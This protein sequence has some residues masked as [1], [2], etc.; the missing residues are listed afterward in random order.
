MAFQ[1]FNINNFTGGISSNQK[2]GIPNSCRFL[3]NLNIHEDLNY[4]TLH[5]KTTKISGST[6]TDLI[7]WAEDGTPYD[8]N[9][10]FYDA[11]GNIYKETSG[12]TWSVDRSGATIA[13]GAAGQGLKVFDDA[14]YYATATT[15]G[16][17]WKLSNSPTYSD[18]FLTDNTTDLDPGISASLDTSGSTYTLPSAISETATNRQTFIPT[19]DPIRAI[20][21]NVNARGTGNWTLT[22]HDSA[23]NSVGALT[24]AN[25]SVAAS[26][27]QKFTFTSPLRITIGNSYHFHVTSSD[28]TGSVVTT[29]LND[30]ETADFHTYFGILISDT[31]WHPMEQILNMLVVGNERYLAT[32]DQALYNPNKLVF[33]PGFKVRAL[34]KWRE[35]IVAAC[36]RGTNIDSFE[37]GRLYFWDGI[38]STFNFFKDVKMGLPNAITNSDERLFGVYGSSGEL[39]INNEPFQKVQDIPKVGRGKKVEVYPGAITQWQGQTLIGVAGSTDDSTSLEQGIYSFGSRQEGQP[40]VLS[41]PITIS[42]GTTQGTT[43]KIGMV[44]GFGKDLYIG[45]RD[46]ST[47]GVDKIIKTDTAATSGSWESLIFDDGKPQKTKEVFKIVIEFEALETGE[48][49]TPKYKINRATNFTS[50]DTVSTVGE[51]RAEIAIHTHFKEIEFG[52]DVTSSTGTF[53][54]VTCVYFSYDDKREE[55]NER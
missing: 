22:V 27:D 48:T 52:F 12:G 35:Y 6:V 5:Q 42:T 19:R 16:R 23:N 20:E 1:D 8:T 54:V 9:R 38:L 34:T 41:F 53:P 26:G 24:I 25:A 18:N 44:K 21:V 49:V 31:E 17:K 47:Y 37:E 10:W 36:W 33:A 3:K 14:L 28:G 51:T 4:V 13:L 29:T 50:G 45:W 7:K 2:T 46:A 32:W 39:Y 11:S 55:M 40:E 30:L 15:I 43:L